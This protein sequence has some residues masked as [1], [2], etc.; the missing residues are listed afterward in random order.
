MIHENTM[1]DRWFIDKLAVL[2]EMEE[3]LKN[4][5]LTE[6]LLREAKRLEFP[7]HVIAQL[8]GAS[9]EEIKNMRRQFKITPAYK[10][11]DTCAEGSGS[12]LWA[13]PNRAGN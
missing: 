3:A 7:D 10:M 11:V 5:P 12:W 1:I 9:T 6:E 4:E 13:Y 8:S 2:V